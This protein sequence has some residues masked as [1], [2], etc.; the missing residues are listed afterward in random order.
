MMDENLASLVGFAIDGVCICAL[1]MFIDKTS[2]RTAR[3]LLAISSVSSIVLL[4][5]GYAMPSSSPMSML[6]MFI[7]VGIVATGLLSFQRLKQL[8]RQELMR[9]R[10]M[11]S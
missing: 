8:K 11:G 2:K 4:F 6:L 1:L 3:W 7:L 10:Q 9:M 5:I